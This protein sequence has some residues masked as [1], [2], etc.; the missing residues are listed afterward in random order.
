MMRLAFATA[1]DVAASSHF[2]TTHLRQG[3]LIAYPTET[4]YGFGGLVQ[5]S[6]LTALSALK[7]RDPAKP[8]LLLI[9]EAED[10]PALEWTVSARR[11][12]ARFWPGP[13]TLALRVRS[14][15]PS[16]ILSHEGTVAVRATPHICLRALLSELGQPITS[17]SANLPGVPPAS[18]A[19]DVAAIL[20]DLG[21]SD[22]L[23]LDGGQLPASLPSTV[24]DC[25]TYEP[26]LV[27][28]G[29]ITIEALNQV[30]EVRHE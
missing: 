4:V 23:I 7:A 8:F 20:R 16:R 15:F 2:I 1:R 17:S 26:R 18:N 12:A 22:V 14:D 6:A 29:A 13:L 21:R 25:S 19:D 9:R 11:L 10:M 5:D 3:G 24:L 30:V 28:A 27:R